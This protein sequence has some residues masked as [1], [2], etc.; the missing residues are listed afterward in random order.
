MANDSLLMLRDIHLPPPI[1]T[2]PLAPGWWIIIILLIIG[3]IFVIFTLKN[4]FK[5]QKPKKEA[6]LLLATIKTKHI[7]TLNINI[8]C[9]EI[10]L[11]L[12][13]VALH[14]HPREMVANLHDKAWLDFLNKSSQNLD[15]HKYH[16]F[17]LLYPYQKSTKLVPQSA[18]TD[19]LILSLIQHTEL[20]IKQQKEPSSCN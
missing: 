6:L 9:H 17:L 3:L 5:K 10:N 4:K 13:R 8:T 15:F 12:K 20:W 7:Q 16:E 19:L 2:L 18:S 1:T 11:L 14:Y